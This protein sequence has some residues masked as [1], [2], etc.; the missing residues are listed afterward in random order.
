M[1]RQPRIGTWDN[2]RIDFQLDTDLVVPDSQPT[3]FAP[4]RLEYETTFTLSNGMGIK[5]SITSKPYKGNK[6]FLTL[7]IEI[8]EGIEVCM[9]PFLW[10]S[11]KTLENEI[12][13]LCEG[14]IAN[15]EE[16]IKR[17]GKLTVNI[18]T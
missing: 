11:L 8:L 10:R 1:P 17:V 15:L 16:F 7:Y 18:E 4:P 12:D 14:R 5:I 9:G 13:Y 2:A 6:R 3:E